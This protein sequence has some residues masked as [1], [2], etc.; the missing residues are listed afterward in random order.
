MSCSPAQCPKIRVLLSVLPFVLVWCLWHSPWS[1]TPLS[2]HLELPMELLL[3]P[4]C[5]RPSITSS[6]RGLVPFL[7]F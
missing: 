4:V 6:G 1:R 2:Q 3:S 7:E 5:H